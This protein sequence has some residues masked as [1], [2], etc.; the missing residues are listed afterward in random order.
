ML[1]NLP[2]GFA[3]RLLLLVMGER[4]P[5]ARERILML[6]T[7][8]RRVDFIIPDVQHVLK[9]ISPR[10]LP[11]SIRRR[12]FRREIVSHHQVLR[13]LELSDYLFAELIDLEVASLDA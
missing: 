3:L 10:G 13:E 7:I 1:G 11:R 12:A 2:S 5:G 8:K 4:L 6:A 9:C